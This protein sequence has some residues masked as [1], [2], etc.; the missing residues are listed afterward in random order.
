M[1]PADGPSNGSATLSR[2]QSLADYTTAML[3]SNFRKRQ[4]MTFRF[5]FRVD[6][7]GMTVPYPSGHSL[8][9]HG[10]H[11]VRD[12]IDALDFHLVLV[13]PFFGSRD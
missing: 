4:P 5:S 2:I 8:F 10:P 9:H 13:Q 7:E 12:A 3:E 1:R 6:P 11:F